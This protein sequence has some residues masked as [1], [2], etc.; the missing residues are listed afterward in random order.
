MAALGT[1]ENGHCR[2]VCEGEVAVYYGTYIS[3]LG[4]TV[5]F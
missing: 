1:E 3:F 2:S 5:L 4:V